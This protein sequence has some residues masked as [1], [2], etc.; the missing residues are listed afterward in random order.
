MTYTV[1]LRKDYEDQSDNQCVLKLISEDSEKALRGSVLVTRQVSTSDGDWKLGEN[2]TSEG[3]VP[4]PNGKSEQREDVQL[5][6]LAP[7][8]GSFLSLVHAKSRSF[9]S[10]LK[11]KD[12]G[13]CHEMEARIM[14][15]GQR[16]VSQQRYPK[17][18][19]GRA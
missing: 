9:R 5:S 8:S 1:T 13:R 3:W 17:R 2:L 12:V 4:I 10:L 16:M 6:G 14:H 18:S 19:F 7:C 15:E 11:A